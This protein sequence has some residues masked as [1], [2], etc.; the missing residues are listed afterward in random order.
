M[1][2]RRHTDFGHHITLYFPIGWKRK[3]RRLFIPRKN[4]DVDSTFFHVGRPRLPPNAWSNQF[5]FPLAT[6]SEQI[7]CQS[8]NLKI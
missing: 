3:I 1:E 7:P 4:L 6:S 8:H 5:P 2:S